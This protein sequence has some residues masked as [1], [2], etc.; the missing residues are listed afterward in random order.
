M[1]G[2]QL[3]GLR[4][5]WNYTQ[6]GAAEMVGVDLRTWRRW[7]RGERK[8]PENMAKLARLMDRLPDVRL[9]LAKMKR[10]RS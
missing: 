8:I 10:K 6:R 5:R 4:Y 9:E 1:T 2:R 7:E 3:Q